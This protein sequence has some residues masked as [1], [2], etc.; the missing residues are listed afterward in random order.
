MAWFALSTSVFIV[1][2]WTSFNND[3]FLFS[4]DQL[5]WRVALGAAG[6]S[7]PI[8][9]LAFGITLYAFLHTRGVVE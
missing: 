7:N 4:F 3:A 9:V 8:A 1:T 5:V 2:R 6:I